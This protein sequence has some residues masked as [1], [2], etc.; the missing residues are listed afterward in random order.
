MLELSSEFKN[1]S[2]QLLKAAFAYLIFD[3]I[4]SNNLSI[5][6]TRIDSSSPETASAAIA[7][8]AIVV[9]FFTFSCLVYLVRDVST[10]TIRRSGVVQADLPTRAEVLGLEPKKDGFLAKYFWVVYGTEV[11][12]F[13]VEAIVPIGIGIFVILRTAYFVLS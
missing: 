5:F 1:S 2:G 3:F 13:V 4:G 8:V 11:L 10:E 6:A 9:G 12:V 7:I